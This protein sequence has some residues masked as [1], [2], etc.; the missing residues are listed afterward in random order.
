MAVYLHYWNMFTLLIN[1]NSNWSCTYAPVWT[2]SKWVSILFARAFSQRALQRLIFFA[3]Y[4]LSPP[5]SGC[6]HAPLL[7]HFISEMGD[8]ATNWRTYFA[9]WIQ[10]RT[11]FPNL[12]FLSRFGSAVGQQLAAIELATSWRYVTEPM[13]RDQSLLSSALLC[14][15]VVW[16]GLNWPAGVVCCQ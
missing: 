11:N 4:F 16:P 5:F 14:V 6:F 10:S 7:F 9:L 13:L 1:L 15:C 3:C 2:L 12:T 8:R